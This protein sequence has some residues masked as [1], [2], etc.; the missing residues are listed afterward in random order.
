MVELTD[1]TIN[2]DTLL[3]S[4]VR[5]E[6]GAAVLF[7]GTTRQWTGSQQT[8]YLV[9]EAYREMALHEMAKLEAQVKSRWK[10]SDVQI[11]HR[12]GRVD[13]AEVSVAIAVSSPHRREAF[14]AGQWLIDEFKERV[15]V[16]KK[17]YWSDREASWI[18]PN[19]AEVA[20]DTHCRDEYQ[21]ENRDKG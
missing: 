15:P 6:S 18:H 17:E 7:V 1:S 12:L 11:V 21:V 10:L 13:I 8:E 16:W 9:Y 4:V 2:T 5:P 20:T 14:E 3:K 19:L